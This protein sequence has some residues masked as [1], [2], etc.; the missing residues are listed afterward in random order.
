MENLYKFIKGAWTPD[1]LKEGTIIHHSGYFEPVSNVPVE[2]IVEPNWEAELKEIQ[3][4]GSENKI[5]I[6]LTKNN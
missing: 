1:N 6:A 4:L 5:N 2:N 3:D